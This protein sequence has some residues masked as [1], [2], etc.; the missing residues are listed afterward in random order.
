MESWVIW[1]KA[2]H[3]ISVTAWMVGLL[4]LPRI[5]VY[6]SDSV[7][8]SQ[9]S[10][11]FKIMERRLLKVIMYP[12]MT[13]VWMTGP[14]LVHNYGYLH[15]H[16]LHVKI[17]LVVI[18]TGFHIYLARQVKLFKADANR[19]SA[20]FFRFINEVPTVLMISIVVLVVVKPI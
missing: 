1:I 16:W 3:I 11:T 13:F 18:L 12:A 19:H 5:F 7:Q 2:L 4:Y 8:N 9:E 17:L 14:Y 10:E 15:S 6:H 20:G